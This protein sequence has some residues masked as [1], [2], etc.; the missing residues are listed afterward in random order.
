MNIAA[1][2]PIVMGKKFADAL[3]TDARHKAFYGGR[4][5]AK[6]WSVATYLTSTA[7]RKKKRI[8]CA[9][10]FQNSIRD[11]SKELLE[12]RI[13]ALGL[14]RQYATTERSIIHLGTGSSFLFVGLERNVES[15]RSL[16]GADIVWVDEARTIKAKSMEILLPTI[17][18]PGSELI[19]CWNPEKPTDPVDAYFRDGDPPPRSIVV[20][21]DHTDNPFFEQTEMPHELETL[22]RGNFNRYKH[23]WLGEYDLSFETKVFSNVEIGHCFVPDNCPPL[24]GMDF[25]FGSD[26]SFVV[27]LYVIEERKEIYIAA[28][29]S[30]RV[31]MVQLPAMVRSVVGDTGHLIKA[32]SSQ[33]GT[34]EF[35]GNQGINIYPAKKGPGSVKSGI[36]WLQGYKIYINPD[37]EAMREEAH[38][39]SWMTD[40]LT[41]K[42][43][44]VPI[45]SNNHGW[46]SVRYATESAQT[47]T[48]S[49]DED[50]GVLQ[51]K[52][53]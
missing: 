28:E 16:E 1:P 36:L 22:K 29:A 2:P 4:G 3:F 21:V 27:K 44:S 13:R 40:K 41:G 52:R 5:S 51:L 39:Y 6:S 33:P 42:A 46:D 17:R 32:D 14:S 50:G 10:Q 53:W 38:M 23:V 26:P 37:C 45:D 9:R 8:V 30:G 15:L 48:G 19:W 25:G 49:R 12:K 47:E 31:P 20:R 18:Q 11:S 43:L 34:I 35:L 24:Y 7:A